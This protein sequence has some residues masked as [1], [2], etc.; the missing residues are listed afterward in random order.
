M[1][2]EEYIWE[3]SLA[4]LAI[5]SG[6]LHDLNIK[7]KN[8]K[9]QEV[10]THI[11]CEDK[12]LELA[13]E[14]EIISKQLDNTMQILVQEKY[15]IST[16][17]IEKLIGLG[18]NG[19]LIA[20]VL[21]YCYGLPIHMESGMVAHQT[22][23][24]RS[25]VDSKMFLKLLRLTRTAFNTQL[26]DDSK[27]E[28]YKAYL[29]DLEAHLDEVHMNKCFYISE[30]LFYMKDKITE[31]KILKYINIV[32]DEM[33]YSKYTSLVWDMLADYINS[34]EEIEQAKL[35]D[36]LEIGLHR[37]IGACEEHRSFLYNEA[38]GQ[39]AIACMFWKINNVY[40]DL[41]QPV[42][43]RGIV[44]LIRT[45]YEKSIWEEESHIDFEKLNRYLSMVP[46]HI[47]C[48]VIECMKNSWLDEAVL[49]SG[50]IDVL[51]RK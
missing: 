4:L 18:E 35:I 44:Q 40:I 43:E 29:A 31:E 19:A 47:M 38:Y 39:I 33:H 22:Y 48:Q 3:S 11:D 8:D 24:L 26:D 15:N 14:S 9:P 46:K 21:C 42:F 25:K 16:A 7:R 23:F 1:Q 30:Y 5:Y 27:L 10:V 50:M 49:L 28:E 37:I 17:Y 2:R 51:S 12:L 13:K 32:M 6:D 34:S 20:G 41:A 45:K 36:A